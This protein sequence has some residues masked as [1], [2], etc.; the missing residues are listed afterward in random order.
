MLPA[1]RA[2]RRR[3]GTGRRRWVPGTA[4]PAGWPATRSASRRLHPEVAPGGAGQPVVAVP[5]VA[6]VEVHPQDL[7][8]APRGVQLERQHPL[9]G[10]PSGPGGPA[11]RG[12]SPAAAPASRRPGRGGAPARTEP[13]DADRIDPGNAVEAAVL[14]GDQRIGHLRRHRPLQR[15]RSAR[16]GEPATRVAAS[17]TDGV[18][19]QPTPRAT[20]PS[21]TTAARPAA[22]GARSPAPASAA[23]GADPGMIAPRI[24]V[25]TQHLPPL[26]V[27]G[28]VR[29]PFLGFSITR[30]NAPD[31]S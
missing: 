26:P 13:E 25:V 2:P 22:G 8:L 5:V 24:A 16:R 14:G 15:R 10:C 23:P 28:T 21:T 30:E 9:G 12:S 18:S 31:L 19:T 11:R 17:P 20:S 3:A 29:C 7:R 4:R 6:V 1:W 27:P